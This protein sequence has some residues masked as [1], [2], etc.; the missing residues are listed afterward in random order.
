VSIFDGEEVRRT[1]VEDGLGARLAFE[2]RS[3]IGR[4]L[5]A[6]PPPDTGSPSLL[7]LGCGARMLPGWVNAD[8]FYL[9]WWRAPPSYWAVDLRYPL[10]CGPDR[11]DGAFC[12]HAIEHLRPAEVRALLGEALRVLRPG[13]WLRV[14]FPDLARYVR[15]YAGHPPHEDFGRFVPRALALRSVTQGWGHRSAWDGELVV[16]ALEEIGFESA[17]EVG[18]REGADA[19]LLVDA[20]ERAWETACVEARKPA[21]PVTGRGGATGA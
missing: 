9:R 14:T 15:A 12:E 1:A 4:V 20:P 3:L 13:G 16:A 18:F 5:F 6:R 19:R 2:L 8:F 10:P 7:N 17:R 21:V 11:F